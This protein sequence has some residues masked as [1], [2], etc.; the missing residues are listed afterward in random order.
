[1]QPS[2]LSVGVEG[3]HIVV[4]MPGTSFRTSFFKLADESRLVESPAMSV[5]KE[6]PSD[7]RKSF[8]A[9]AWEVANAKARE[10]GWIV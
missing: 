8:E 4:T 9:L 10:L 5:E 1:M 7:K 6:T 2:D 3:K